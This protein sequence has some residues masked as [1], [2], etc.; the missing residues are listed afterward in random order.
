MFP[1]M[2]FMTVQREHEA[3]LERLAVRRPLWRERNARASGKRERV[4]PLPVAYCLPL[5]WLRGAGRP[6]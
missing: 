6:A 4:V 2:M 5:S 3:E 1:T